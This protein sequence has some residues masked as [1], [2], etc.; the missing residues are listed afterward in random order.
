MGEK[1]MTKKEMWATIL[2]F[3]NAAEADAEIISGVEHEI[4]LLDKRAGS[5]SVNAKHTAE[6]REAMD[7]VTSV[8][9]NAN[10]GVRATA[11]AEATGFS[12]Q[13]VT[14]L[15]KKMVDSGEVVRAEV[16]KVAFFSLGE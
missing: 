12:V 8:L 10:E 2:V 3:L 13:R 11:I 14:A 6:Q 4:A 5:K 7:T 16:K 1:K 15:V 9:A